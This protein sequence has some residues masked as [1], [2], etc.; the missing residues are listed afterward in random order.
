MKSP[1]QEIIKIIEKIQPLLAMDGKG[2][3]KYYFG[4]FEYTLSQLNKPHDLEKIAENI[5]KIYGGM[6]TFNDITLYK[7][8]RPAIKENPLFS[9][10]RSSLFSVCRTAVGL[11]GR[12]GN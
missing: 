9:D 7:N 3:A 11:C 6:G 4:F 1:S 2:L 5:L 8:D 10:F 12:T